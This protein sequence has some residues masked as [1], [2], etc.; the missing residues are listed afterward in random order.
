MP[1]A[2]WA[3]DTSNHLFFRDQQECSGQYNASQL[4]IPRVIFLVPILS[5]VSMEQL[6]FFF[7]FGPHAKLNP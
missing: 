3:Y 2:Y 4:H 1:L 7:Q 6:D 5:W